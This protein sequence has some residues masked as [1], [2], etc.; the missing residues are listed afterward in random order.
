MAIG[1]TFFLITL[2]H[3]VLG[4]QFPKSVALQNP[5]STSLWIAAPLNLFAKLT[6]P[7]VALMNIMCNGLLRLFGFRL[8]S[9]E[10]SVHS[11]EELLLLIDDTE[12]AGVIE[13]EQADLVQNVFRLSDKT[14]RDCMVPRERMAALDLSTPP[15]KILDAVRNGAHTRM[16][17]YDG[18]VDR[19]VGVVNTKELFHLYSLHGVAILDDAIYPAQFLSP[20]ESIG[21]ALQLF[22]KSHKP[23]AL[24]RDDVGKIHGMITLEDILEEI[25]GDIEDE[26]D[27]KV[28]KLVL[29]RVKKKLGGSN[30]AQNPSPPRGSATT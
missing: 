23:I 7:L 27:R 12:E 10:E 2:L 6:R 25:V 1:L 15:D 16:P 24:V 26:H 13:R 9:G 30:Q 11:V 8:V 19:I 17:V 21:V 5:D 29:R 14:V 20:D 18:E 4:E 28:P 3:V 22:R